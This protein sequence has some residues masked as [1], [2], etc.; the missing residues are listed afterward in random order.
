ME[1]AWADVRRRKQKPPEPK[2]LAEQR[3]ALC[4]T[5]CGEK[6]LPLTES[7]R[8]TYLE[9]MVERVV[10]HTLDQI[11][12][13]CLRSSLGRKLTLRREGTVDQSNVEVRRHWWEIP[14]RR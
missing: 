14:R 2:H 10:P 12:Y 8:F 7:F 5:L 9:D 4:L 1:R 13:G 3:G 6:F 11:C